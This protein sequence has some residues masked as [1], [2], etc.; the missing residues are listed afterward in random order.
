VTHEFVH[1]VIHQM[2][3]GT[4]AWL[5]EGLAT[6]LEPVDHAWLTARLSKENLIPFAQLDEAFHTADG[7]EALIA[8]AESYALT[9]AIAERLGP[10][11]PTFL[12]YVSGGTPADQALAMF[13]VKAS[14]LKL[15][16]PSTPGPRPKR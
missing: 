2:Y 5:H 1:A 4:P 14:D 9:R 8:Y 11:L 12:G 6:Y 10:N 13:N 15:T 3:P 7:E 16:L